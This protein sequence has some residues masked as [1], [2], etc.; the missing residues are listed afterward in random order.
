MLFYTKSYN[1]TSTPAKIL[2]F[3]NILKLN[4]RDSYFKVT[5]ILS[6]GNEW[7]KGKIVIKRRFNSRTKRRQIP[8]K[9][10]RE[11]GAAHSFL[12]LDSW[13][14]LQVAKALLPGAR[15]R[16]CVCVCVCVC[17][18]LVQ[19]FLFVSPLFP[20]TMV[21]FLILRCTSFCPSLPTPRKLSVNMYFTEANRL[22][23]LWGM[24]SFL[25]TH[26]SYLI[27]VWR[28]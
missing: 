22:P 11:P 15:A 24:W 6:M 26:M 28:I 12:F 1:P 10:I 25:K 27:L 20:L 19:Y 18:G 13:E 23:T 17:V 8:V 5:F 9:K 3:S 4:S 7:L 16:V 2:P 21:D 14:I